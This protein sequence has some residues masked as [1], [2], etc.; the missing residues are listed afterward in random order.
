MKLLGPLVNDIDVWIGYGDDW[1]LEPSRVA[2][3]GPGVWTTVVS[4]WVRDGG[5]GAVRVRVTADGSMPIEQFCSVSGKLWRARYDAGT[6]AWLPRE[7]VVEEVSRQ[8]LRA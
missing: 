1:V 3:D 2:V 5:M 6:G 8:G 4:G 7:L